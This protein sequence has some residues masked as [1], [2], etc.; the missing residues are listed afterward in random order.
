MELNGRAMGSTN[1]GLLGNYQFSRREGPGSQA[2][3]EGRVE[4]GLTFSSSFQMWAV[5]QRPWDSPVWCSGME[6]GLLLKK[7]LPTRVQQSWA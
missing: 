7:D 1:P 2:G 4:G 5:G 3:L 6:D